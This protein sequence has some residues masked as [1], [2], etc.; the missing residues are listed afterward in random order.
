MFFFSTDFHV[1]TLSFFVRLLCEPIAVI[2]MKKI[3]AATSRCF[4]FAS[5]FLLTVKYDCSLY[6][7]SPCWGRFLGCVVFLFKLL[8][9]FNGQLYL[10]D[11][12]NGV[13]IK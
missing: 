12:D 2:R 13:I 3:M 8:K 9:Y 4:V 5:C 7:S 6:L 11:G 10:G 1:P